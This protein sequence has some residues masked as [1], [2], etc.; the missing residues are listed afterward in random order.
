MLKQIVHGAGVALIKRILLQVAKKTRVQFGHLPRSVG[1]EDVVQRRVVE[2]I[3]TCLVTAARRDA[4]KAL[5][6]ASTRLAEMR[7]RTSV[8]M[9]ALAASRQGRRRA[10]GVLLLILVLMG[11]VARHIRWVYMS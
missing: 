9:L 2:V 8:V 4:A 3:L 11:A 5:V 10:I 7:A 1:A 6:T